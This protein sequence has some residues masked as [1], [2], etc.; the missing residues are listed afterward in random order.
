M[1]SKAQG[2]GALQT[3]EDVHS[4]PVNAFSRIVV[5]EIA[6]VNDEVRLLSINQSAEHRFGGF[7]CIIAGVEMSVCQLQQTEWTRSGW[8]EEDFH[9]IRRPGAD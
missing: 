2:P 9:M 5:D 6:R 7:V 4:C 1:V 3:I 8:C